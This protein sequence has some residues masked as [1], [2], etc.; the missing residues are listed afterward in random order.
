MSE[1][2]QRKIRIDAYSKVSGMA[3]FPGD[4]SYPNQLFMKTLF[5]KHVPAIIKE[6]NTFKAERLSGV[7]T[8][9]TAKDVPN[10]EHGLHKKDNPVLCGP[11]SNKAFADRIRHFGDQV[12]LVIAESENIAEMALS[13]IDIDYE[14]VHPIFDPKEALKNKEVLIHPEFKSNI[15]QHYKIRR[16]NI[17]LGFKEADTIIECEYKTGMQEHAFLQPEAGLGYLDENGV[18]TIITGG[19][20]AH[21]DQKQIAYALNLPFEKV[22]VIYSSIGGAF[23]G[24]E[25][26]SIQISLA[27]AVLKLSNM[28]IYRPVK[29]VWDRQESFLGHPKRHSYIIQAKWGAKKGG[30]ITAADMSILQDG[31]AYLSTSTSVLG[32]TAL[33]SLGPYKIPNVK[34]DAYGV[35]TNNP[36]GG[37][38]RGFGA[39][40]GTFVSESQISKLADQLSLDPFEIRKINMVQDGEELSTGSKPRSFPVK[41]VLEDSKNLFNLNQENK[42]KRPSLNKKNDLLDLGS[43]L[44]GVGIAFGMKN[45][46]LSFGAHEECTATIELIGDENIE[47]AILYHA[48]AEVGQGVHTIMTQ[49]VAEE[50]QIDVN[51]V[52]LVVTDTLLTD[53]SGPVSASRMTFMA[54]NAIIGAGADALLKWRNGERPAIGSFTYYPPGTDPIDSNLGVAVNPFFSYGYASVIVELKVD[55]FTGRIYISHVYVSDD[56]GKVINPSLVRGQIEGAI[57]QAIGYCIM[58]DLHVE[59]GRIK[60][61][62]FSKYLI[63]GILDIPKDITISL[64]EYDDEIG[65]WG[66]HGVGEM[67]F[68]PFAAAVSAALFDA[69][70][71]WFNE[72]PFTPERILEGILIQRENI[73][74]KRNF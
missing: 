14:D 41:N 50:I 48:A 58:E 63:P 23:G 53:D 19:Q 65:P 22:R 28:G 71:I 57:V 13:L 26:N 4:I 30:I 61:D 69:T 7:I 25:E 59:M 72:I 49:M 20:W 34:V 70:G 6:I 35:Y 17:S 52:R 9:I 47:E 3:L 11:G 67:P 40:Q 46:G 38:M 21:K 16:G 44:S 8:V 39:P 24:R 37:A 33:M 12:A 54:G 51:R 64:L 2:G 68:V 29:L 32:N 45:S 60:A 43:T 73:K 36:P 62:N 1:I 66:A 42:S 56:L 10:N 74:N 5:S 27:L 31:G 15:Y 55:V 18:I